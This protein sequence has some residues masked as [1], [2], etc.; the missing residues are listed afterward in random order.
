MGRVLV[1]QGTITIIEGDF[2]G[3]RM[4]ESFVPDRHMNCSKTSKGD[5]LCP[6]ITN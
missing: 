6:P 5:L 1:V 2:R 3:Y 4:S